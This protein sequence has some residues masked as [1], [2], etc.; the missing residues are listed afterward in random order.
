MGEVHLWLPA[1]VYRSMTQALISRTDK[2][3]ELTVL[4]EVR[5]HLLGEKAGNLNSEEIIVHAPG[6]G[7]YRAFSKPPAG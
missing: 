5:K 4:L 7:K 3:N 2:T 6:V 1:D